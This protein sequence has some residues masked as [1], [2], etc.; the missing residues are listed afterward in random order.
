MPDGRLYVL[1]R[2]MDMAYDAMVLLGLFYDRNKIIMIKEGDLPTP[3]LGSM[4][5]TL[6]KKEYGGGFSAEASFYD[7][8]NGHEELMAILNGCQKPAF[9]SS[10]KITEDDMSRPGGYL[11][12]N[13]KI[14]CGTVLYHILQRAFQK[15]LPYG[16]LTGVRPVKMAAICLADGMDEDQTADL[17]QRITGISREKA[18]LLYEV[19]CQ[20]R[21]YMDSD[22][23][24][25]NIYIGIPFCASRC[26]Y[27]SF[28]SYPIERLSSLVDPYLDALSKE[29]EFGFQ[30]IKDNNLRINSL[31]I[32]GGTP[33]ALPDNR[34]G[35]LLAMVRDFFG[36]AR[37]FTV[38]AG[39]PDTINREKLRMIKESG[40]TRISI[41]PQ[42]M[43]RETLRLIG[44]NHTP[45]DI[46]EKFFIARKL[47]FD[48]INMD[49]IAGLPGEDL[50]MFLRTLRQIEELKPDN[51]TVHTMA[52]KRASI[53][54]QTTDEYVSASDDVV[55]QMLM[56]AREST[57][58]MGMKP[59]YLYRQKN[60]LANLENTGYAV[61]GKGCRYNVETMVERQSILAFGAGSI[62]KIVFNSE[63]RI[64]RTDNVKDVALYIDRV[65]EMIVRKR[66]LLSKMK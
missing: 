46:A 57:K 19:A 44:R 7:T 53:L 17:L 14:I 51:L 32:G 1:I 65:D 64:E 27:C 23:T 26:L 43:N 52:I 37:E 35:R 4:L 49:I 40:A 60:M 11:M 5:I 12:R 45:E 42:S 38:E 34:F 30:W 20:E 31:Y 6:D 16:S 36:K 15:E 21:S 18:R 10:M 33:T 62:S 61:P 29:M 8:V 3:D 50:D 59:Y 2:G 66:K 39:R 28:T 24:E 56:K 48:N 63:N 22:D 58:R 13:R 25:V 9:S 55:E 47:G 54:H 41:N